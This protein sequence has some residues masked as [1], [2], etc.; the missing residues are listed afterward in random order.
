MLMELGIVDGEVMKPFIKQ[1]RSLD[2]DGEGRV[3]IQDLRLI[4]QMSEEELTALRKKRASSNKRFSVAAGVI[5]IPDPPDESLR[6]SSASSAKP[7]SAADAPSPTMPRAA[8]SWMAPAA[9]EAPWALLTPAQSLP[10]AKRAG[11][12]LDA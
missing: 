8:S 7:P 10:P 1:F 2:I 6:E 5:T 4:K 12:P 9:G 11:S 3:G